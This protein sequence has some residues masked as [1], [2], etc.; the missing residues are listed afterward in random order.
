MQPG[1]DLRLDDHGILHP[2]HSRHDD[3][4]VDDGGPRDHDHE[5][6]RHD[7]D[8]GRDDEHAPSGGQLGRRAPDHDRV[9]SPGLV[10]WRRM[11]GR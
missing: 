9:R 7:H 1:R 6:R 8:V 11:V 4:V 5:R 2:H 10:G 3:L